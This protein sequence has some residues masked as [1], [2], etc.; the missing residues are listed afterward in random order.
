M[1]YVAMQYGAAIQCNITV[2]H[3]MSHFDVAL[4]TASAASSVTSAMSDYV[5]WCNTVVELA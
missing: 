5:L 1:Y 4:L 3:S 2:S